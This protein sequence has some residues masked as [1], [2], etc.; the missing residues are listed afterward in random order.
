MTLTI[1]Y[2]LQTTDS[3]Q[4]IRKGFE[5][6]M[7]RCFESSH[8]ASIWRRKRFP[9]QVSGPGNKGTVWVITAIITTFPQAYK[10]SP[11]E[12]AQSMVRRFSMLPLHWQGLSS[13]RLQGGFVTLVFAPLFTFPP[14][15]A[16]AK[17]ERWRWRGK[18][19]ER[20]TCGS[21][22]GYGEQRDFFRPTS[23]QST[24]CAWTV[25][26]FKQPKKNNKALWKRDFAKI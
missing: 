9:T 3:K 5:A 19:E 26:E 2:S 21:D 6:L 15:L 12:K 8:Q 7:N 17:G 23:F 4:N 25:L 13:P 18:R 22:T 11:C 16:H 10:L 14:Q 24:V 20:L 1:W